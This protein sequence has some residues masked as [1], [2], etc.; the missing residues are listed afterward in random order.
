VKGIIAMR[1]RAMLIAFV[2]FAVIGMTPG[3]V[4]HAPGEV[5]IQSYALPDGA[6]PHDVAPEA[7]GGNVW[8]T[9]QQQA[10]LGR[11]DPV[12]GR[13]QHIPLGRGS[14]PHGVVVGPAGRVWVT[15][16]GLNAVVAVDSGT[17][18]ITRYPLPAPGR[19]ANLNTAAFDKKGVLWFTGQSGFYGRL[20]PA[21]GAMQ[22][23]DAP[24]GGGPYGICATPGGEI[25]Y[26]SLAG[27]YLARVDTGTGTVKV[28]D[29][30]AEG[31]GTR[32][33]WADSKGRLWVTEWKTGRLARYD[34]IGGQWRRWKLPGTAPAAYAVYV[35]ETDRVWVSDFGANAILRF[36][37][38]GETF[39]SFAISRAGAAVRQMLGRPGEV[40]TA[41]SGT[42][43]LSVYRFN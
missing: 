4:R 29:P 42:D 40:W 31:A 26:V 41:E 15:D 43:R 18:A 23:F 1:T 10:A 16:S 14:R 35:D 7:A 3:M 32:R 21:T 38:A 2:L 20:D 19:Y 34:P 12:T 9:A 17:A 39:E 37:P 6:H 30:P 5:R 22:V 36:D 27:S 8:Y 24:R 25:W 28:F 13:T 33:V 11:L